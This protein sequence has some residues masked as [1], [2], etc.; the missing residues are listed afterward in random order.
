MDI[1][2]LPV[3]MQNKIFY[4]YYAEHTLAKMIKQRVNYMYFK[5][6]KNIEDMDH[7][8][9]NNFD[10]NI[11]KHLYYVFKRNQYLRH[12]YNDRARTRNEKIQYFDKTI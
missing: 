4:Y 8:L 10:M 6:I 3:E 7:L 5:K 1:A 12:N 2:S 9:N 11:V